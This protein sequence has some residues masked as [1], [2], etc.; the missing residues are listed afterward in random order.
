MFERFVLPSRRAVMLAQEEARLANHDRI[1]SG[2]LL[3]GLMAEEHGIAAQV[4]TSFGLSLVSVRAANEELL[5]AGTE[6]PSG[7]IP[8][9]QD[10][11]K[12]LEFALRESLQL[13]HNCIGVEHLLL[14]IIR[15][16]G[17]DG[18]RILTGQGPGLGRWRQEVIV[19]ISKERPQNVEPANLVPSASFDSETEALNAFVTLLER[20]DGDGRSRILRYLNSRFGPSA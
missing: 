13:G 8:F 14:G 18:S 16:E 11:K 19:R 6:P 15:S 4:M 3:C 2:H 20:L 17:C 5:P 1:T 7:H 10:A 12:V 9:T